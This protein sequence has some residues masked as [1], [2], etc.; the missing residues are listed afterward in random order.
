M[1]LAATD[2]LQLAVENALHDVEIVDDLLRYLVTE[3][4]THQAC[5]YL[6]EP[7]CIAMYSVFPRTVT[8]TKQRSRL[9]VELHVSILWRKSSAHTLDNLNLWKVL[10]HH[11]LQHGT[12]HEEGRRARHAPKKAAQPERRPQQPRTTELR[13]A[14]QAPR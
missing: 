2:R 4:K 5:V 12:L 13:P 1:L 3:H 6:Q 9:R 7:L 8:E 14:A 11:L 10:T